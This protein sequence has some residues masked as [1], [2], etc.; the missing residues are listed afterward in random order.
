ME[1][2]RN[3]YVDLYH[4]VKGEL[5]DLSAMTVALKERKNVQ[6]ALKELHKKIDQT[7]T[8]IDSVA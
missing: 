2:Q 7:K 8:D 5:Y 1:K 3:P 4:W 6:D